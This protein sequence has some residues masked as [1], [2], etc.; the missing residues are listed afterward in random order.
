MM[1]I[2]E[3]WRIQAKGCREGCD[4]WP[5]FLCGTFTTSTLSLALSLVEPLHSWPLAAIPTMV[6]MSLPLA[7]L[8][9]L[10]FAPPSMPS[11]SPLPYTSLAVTTS[12]RSQHQLPFLSA[13]PTTAPSTLA[14]IFLSTLAL[15]QLHLGSA[16]L[17]YIL[18]SLN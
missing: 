4:S 7:R 18:G 17:L 15:F 10:Q 6:S 9:A 1:L 13:M 5:M 8:L 2:G 14:I 12:S 3:K 16:P 11:T